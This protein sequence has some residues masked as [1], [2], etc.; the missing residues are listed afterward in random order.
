MTEAKLTTD[1][2]GPDD[3]LTADAVLNC[4]AITTAVVTGRVNVPV[5]VIEVIVGVV[6]VGELIVGE[7]KVL[8]VKVCVAPKVTSVSA[9]VVVG[10]IIDDVPAAAGGYNTIDP[11]VDPGNT[12]PAGLATVPPPAVIE[13]EVIVFPVRV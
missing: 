7:V 11:E 5:F 2:A 13:A 8:E 4:V 6:I 12:I 10:K 9:D 3:E 1:A